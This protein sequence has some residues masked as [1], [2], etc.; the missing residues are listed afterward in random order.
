VR[1]LKLEDV[2][3]LGSKS[4]VT[5]IHF[6]FLSYSFKNRLSALIDLV[7]VRSALTLQ[8]Q[9]QQSL[10]GTLLITARHQCPESGDQDLGLR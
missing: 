7:L 6:Y 1:H 2:A 9:S 8:E 5:I 4:S 10:Q 3:F